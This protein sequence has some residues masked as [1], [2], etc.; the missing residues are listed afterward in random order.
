MKVIFIL[1]L[2]NLNIYSIY[3]Q[4]AEQQT[5]FNMTGSMRFRGFALGRDIPL[6]RKTPT[7]P[8]YNPELEFANQ[9][10]ANNELLTNELNSRL[11]GKQSTLFTTSIINN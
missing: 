5:K 11:A 3:S 2:I 9:N 8:I 7:Y 4:D 1:I 6:I 10:T